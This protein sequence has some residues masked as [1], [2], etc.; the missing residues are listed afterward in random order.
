MPLPY[1][2]TSSVVS[3]NKLDL[4]Q[5]NHISNQLKRNERYKILFPAL[6]SFIYTDTHVNQLTIWRK[7]CI[8]LWKVVGQKLTGINFEKKDNLL[9]L[10]DI[11]CGESKIVLE[12]LGED[13]WKHIQKDIL[14]KL[15]EIMFPCWTPNILWNMFCLIFDVCINV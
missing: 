12:N 9:P 6:S 3:Y 5:K 4:S 1:T 7:S 13:K 11:E 8:C 10:K 15:F 14:P 2:Y